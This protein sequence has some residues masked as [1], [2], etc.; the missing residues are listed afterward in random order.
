MA[1]MAGQ[2][3]WILT[4]VYG[5][6]LDPDTEESIDET[7]VQGAFSSVENAKRYITAYLDENHSDDTLTWESHLDGRVLIC[8][9]GEDARYEI[10]RHEVD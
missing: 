2:F 4:T 9:Y 6:G 7:F 3:V 5:D 1:P 10:L 8:K